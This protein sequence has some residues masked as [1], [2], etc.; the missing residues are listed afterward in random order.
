MIQLRSSNILETMVS[1]EN[2]PEVQ[3][4][5]KEDMD[6][7]TPKVVEIIDN[8]MEVCYNEVMYHQERYDFFIDA[9]MRQFLLNKDKAKQCLLDVLLICPEFMPLMW[10]GESVGLPTDAPTSVGEPA[11]NTAPNSCTIDDLRQIS[12]LQAAAIA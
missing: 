5:F 12:P 8:A 6:N 11:Y 2:L 3:K 1:R 9:D 4:F 10:G 7:P